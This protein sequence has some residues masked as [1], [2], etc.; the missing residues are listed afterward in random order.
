MFRI[1][2]IFLEVTYKCLTTGLYNIHAIPFTLSQKEADLMPLNTCKIRLQ[3]DD[4]ET[5]SKG[6]FSTNDVELHISMLTCAR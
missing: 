5:T 2:Y 6:V 1:Y 3:K 4:Q